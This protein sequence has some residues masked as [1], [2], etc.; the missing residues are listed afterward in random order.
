M[1]AV[2]PDD[3]RLPSAEGAEFQEREVALP[4]AGVAHDL[5]PRIS[6][7]DPAD[8]PIPSGHEEEWRFT[9]MRRLRGLSDGTAGVGSDLALTSVIPAAATAA[10][11]TVSQVERT[12]ARLGS[13][14]QPTDR[15]AAGAFAGFQRAVVV[16]VPA[17]VEVAG[18]IR[19]TLRGSGTTHYGHLFVELGS[20]ARAT[21]LVEHVGS[22]VVA[23]NSELR[24]GDGA[25]LT[26]ASVQHWDDDAVHA[27]QQHARLGRDATYRSVVVTIGGDLVRVLP[28]VDYAGPGGSAELVGVYFTADGEHHEHRLFVDHG[29]ADCHSDVIYKGALQGKGAH[30]VWIGDVLIRATAHGTKTYELNRNLVLTRGARADSV[31]NLEIET[32]QIE[33]A[34]HASAT[35]RFDDEQLFYLMSRGLPADV[36]RRLVVR[37]FFADALA[38]IGVP[39]VT[40]TLIA[41]VDARLGELDPR[42]DFSDETTFAQAQP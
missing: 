19:L 4:P 32:G 29:F 10:G 9:P 40:H 11:V 6:S 16:S 23:T 33:G 24:I 42:Y 39:E 30:A 13:V 38:R 15:V 8:F 34:G 41:A 31:P 25:A 27:T 22:G 3:A 20:N 5:S 7:T 1:T 18:V 12:D 28:S 37:G 35:G 26:F 21:V 17:G 14:H 36:A 2:L